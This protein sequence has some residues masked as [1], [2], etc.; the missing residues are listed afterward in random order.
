MRLVRTSK[1][2]PMT[3]KT[4]NPDH[5]LAQYCPLWHTRPHGFVS[6][7]RDDGKA[8]HTHPSKRVVL[9][10]GIHTLIRHASFPSPTDVGLHNPPPSGSPASPLAHRSGLRL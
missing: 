7:G 9:G 4:E 5:P 1:P 10:R 8:P 3:E 6:N 2:Q